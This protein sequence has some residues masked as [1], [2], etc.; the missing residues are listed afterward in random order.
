MGDDLA[1]AV[2]VAVDSEVKAPV[3]IDARLPS[4]FSF[5]K[6]LGAKR[7]MVKVADR[8]IDLLDEGFLH[9]QRRVEQPL[10]GYLRKVDVHLNF[11][12]LAGLAVAAPFS[13]EFAPLIWPTSIV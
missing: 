6:L 3:V 5:V 2:S 11:L 4:A 12:D 8:K 7:G 10:D 13:F 9:R 1:D